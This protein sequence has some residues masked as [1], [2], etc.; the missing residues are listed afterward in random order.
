[1]NMEG[2]LTKETRIPILVTVS[3]ESQTLIDSSRN[4]DEDE[5]FLY[6]EV[7]FEIKKFSA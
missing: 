2:L 7:E 5:K 1:M 3:F 4:D 6:L